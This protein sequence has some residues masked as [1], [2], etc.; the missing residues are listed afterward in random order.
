MIRAFNIL[1]ILFLLYSCGTSYH[2][3]F[4]GNE[5]A[6]EP[7]SANTYN[8]FFDGGGFVYPP[9]R[10]PG[11]HF[12]KKIPPHLSNYYQ[13]EEEFNRLS[14][15]YQ[16]ELTDNDSLNIE[17]L[18]TSL[19]NYH[20]N[21]INQLSSKYDHLIF[22]IHGYNMTY[23]QNL[24]PYAL[25]KERITKSLDGDVFFV[26]VFWDGLTDRKTKKVLDEKQLYL[27]NQSRITEGFSHLAIWKQAN[28][29][30][31]Y[32]GK[33]FRRILSTI[34]KKEIVVV[35]HSLGARVIASALF[36]LKFDQNKTGKQYADIDQRYHTI[37]KKTESYNLPQHSIRVGMIA[38]AIDGLEIFSQYFQDKNE[39]ET[40]YHFLIGYNVHDK[41]LKK[42]N[43]L[44]DQSA[45]LF[46]DTSLGTLEADILEVK[47][48]FSDNN[49]GDYFAGFDFS[50]SL[51]DFEQYKHSPIFYIE[52]PHFPGFINL[53]IPQE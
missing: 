47:Q 50:K 25:M 44:G 51:H 2:Q 32:V 24:Y 39:H 40:N 21:Q 34:E 22:L 38:P 8:L 26:Q 3:I 48:L 43:V 45:N 46:G 33:E 37:S 18:Q 42:F 17:L 15:K 19:L 13:N 28:Y 29:N 20:T 23:R 7:F 30:S 14:N 53:L 5:S 36:D 10:I 6:I 35:T 11:G 31:L 9:E 1:F 52:N 41:V 12:S 49:K 4:Y 16:I 27:Q